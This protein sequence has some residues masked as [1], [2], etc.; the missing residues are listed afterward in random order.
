MAKFHG[1]RREWQYLSDGGHFENTGLYEL[2]RPARGIKLIVVCDDG[3]D[4][5]YRFADLA[6]LVRLARI[7]HGVQI[8]VDEEIADPA[9]QPRLARVFGTLA[10]FRRTPEVAAAGAPD[11]AHARAL[12]DKC[13]LLLNVFLAEDDPNTA[14]PRCRIIVLKPRVIAAAP[15]DVREYFATHPAFPQ[16]PTTDQYFDEAQWESY[17]ALGLAIAEQV[18][19]RG[20]D[21]DNGEALWAY[22]AGAPQPRGRPA[23]GR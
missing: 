4:P 18:F 1:L 6:N 3:C 16:E 17:R 8:T 22:L 5:D 20:A 10:E 2:L 9:R 7:D 23:P 21:H 13:A 19:G 11:G 12:D 15:I 14:A